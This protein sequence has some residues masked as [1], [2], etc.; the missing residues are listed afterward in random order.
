MPWIRA[1]MY[2][3]ELIAS[4]PHRE[5]PI[6]SKSKKMALLKRYRCYP[7][8][9]TIFRAEH[10]KHHET[11]G[12]SEIVFLRRDRVHPIQGMSNTCQIPHKCFCPKGVD[13]T[14]WDL[15]FFELNILSTMMPWIRAKLYFW[16]LVIPL[17]F[18]AKVSPLSFKK[19]AAL[20]RTRRL[21]N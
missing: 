19:G 11:M 20:L 13:V 16:E 12:P 8:K 1:E 15:K 3:W 5:Y 4:I 9:S 2:F 10:F 6:H 17:R 21:R 7:L 14:P 18:Q